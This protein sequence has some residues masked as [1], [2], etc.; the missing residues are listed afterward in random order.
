[1]RILTKLKLRILY[2]DNWHIV[3]WIDGDKIFIYKK[4]IG[5][6]WLNKQD[7]EIKIEKLWLKN[8]T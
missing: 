1:M 4:G 8:L 7:C 2:Q 3:H 5:P 6:I